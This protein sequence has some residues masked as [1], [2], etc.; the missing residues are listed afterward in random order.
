MIFYKALSNS[1]QFGR[2]FCKVF[3]RL[4]DMTI[5]EYRRQEAGEEEG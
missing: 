2:A 5:S 1:D 4:T 3:K